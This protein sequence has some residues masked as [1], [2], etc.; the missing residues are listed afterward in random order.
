MAAICQEVGADQYLSP[1]SARDYLLEDFGHFEN[2][3]ISVC[4]HDYVHPVYRQVYDPF[5]SHASVL[6]VLMMKGREAMTVIQSGRRESQR[7]FR[8]MEVGD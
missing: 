4:L 7:L 8:E 3:S 2:R 5:F 1:V 6:D